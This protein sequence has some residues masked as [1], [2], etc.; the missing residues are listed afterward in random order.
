MWSVVVGLICNVSQVRSS[1]VISESDYAAER[2]SPLPLLLL[3]LR[4]TRHLNSHLMSRVDI[5]ASTSVWQ[6]FYIYLSSKNN[7]VGVSRMVRTQLFVKLST[8]LSVGFLAIST[9]EWQ[10]HGARAGW[11]EPGGLRHSSVTVCHYGDWDT[12]R[13]LSIVSVGF[14]G[15]SAREPQ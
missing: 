7:N 15:L 5:S 1:S 6:Y 2:S 4:L 14:F 9:C 8:D 11:S 10:Q 13:T 12:G 3:L